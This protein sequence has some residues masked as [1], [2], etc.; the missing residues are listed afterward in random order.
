MKR[1]IA[2][3]SFE[4]RPV[5]ALNGVVVSELGASEWIGG[6]GNTFCRQ[7]F[8]LASLPRAA[9]L[10]VVA[11]PHSYAITDWQ[12]LPSKYPYDN[13][14]LGGSFVKYRVFLNGVL[15]AAGPFRSLQDGVPLLMECEV[16]ACLRCGPNVIAVHSRGE[17]RGFALALTM[18]DEEG[19]C[20]TIGSSQ[21]WRQREAN[22]VYR[23]ICWER[24]GLD[25]FAKG[26]ASPGE[27]P[28]HI[29]G[30]AYP[31]GWK[32]VEFDDSSWSH[33][34]GFG[35]AGDAC[36]ISRPPR[37][38]FTRCE[39]VAVR[40]LGPGNYL[41]DFG[42]PVFGGMELSG[43]AGGGAIELRLAE[44][45]Q[46]SGHARYQLR[47]ENCFQELWTFAPDSEPLSHFGTRMFRYAEVVGW[48]GQFDA[49]RIQA[50]ALGM[51]FDESRSEFRC[52]ERRLETVW[53]LCK[54]TVVH[55]TADVFTDC[56]TRER[57]AYEGDTYVT[58]LTH[59]G[60]EGS[61]EISRRTL[62][63]LTSHP[64]WPCEWWQCFIPLFREYLLHSGDYDFVDQHYAFL[65]DQTTFHRLMVD[66]L[67]L[68]FPREIIVDW[69]AHERDGFEFGAGNAIGNAFAYWDLQ[70]LSEVAGFLGREDEAESFAGQAEV[71][72]EGFNR[73]LYNESTGLYV[74][75][76]GSAHSS[77]H[78]NMYALRFGLVPEDRRDHCLSFI[79]QRGMGCSVFGAQFLLEMLFMN[80]AP[81]HAVALM[82]SDGERSWLEMI[83]HGAVATTESWLTNPKQNMSW[84][85][86][87]GSS[88]ANVI[89][90]HLFG[91][92]PTSPGW[93]TFDE[94]P[95]PGGLER[96][97]LRIT[98]PRGP[99]TSSFLR[100]GD[101][102]Q[103][104]TETDFG[105][106]EDGSSSET[107][108]RER[109]EDHSVCTAV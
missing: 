81:D 87:W 60:T 5:R 8:F 2:T 50:I 18:E 100:V 93:K 107:M 54:N 106:S 16:A 77:F 61:P 88:P 71:L 58:M 73:R 3:N 55:T 12:I 89:V 67:I 68:E 82:T 6:P 37:Y 83:R 14:L 86:P 9:T 91:L 32:E 78:A 42:R 45:L 76:L 24:P 23:S 7:E 101:E 46:P 11:D 102:Y 96:G 13:Q 97:R 95:S 26:G 64:T 105:S 25:Q 75:S 34:R 108:S 10:R 38:Q 74:D 20:S 62:A 94:T 99:I 63:Y 49:A 44:E 103:V 98:T 53:S 21:E 90:R 70:S 65:R 30:I 80:D 15:V 4:S 40:E 28:E 79:K 51:P 52:S 109:K 35:L 104:A 66:G 29:D 1:S 72:R 48:H 92:R 27:Y 43:P 31:Q 41:V 59:F 85:H 39:P 69:P 33:A 22:T 56:L 36:E 19:D 57:L 47:T 17:A 84:A